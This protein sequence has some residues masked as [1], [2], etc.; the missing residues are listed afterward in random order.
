M[1]KRTDI[2]KV[3]VIGSDRPPSLTMPEHRPASPL[4]KRAMRSFSQTP[5]PQRS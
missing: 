2:K 5:T 4:R 3:L 1:P